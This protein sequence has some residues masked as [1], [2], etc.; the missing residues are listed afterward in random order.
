MYTDAGAI[1]AFTAAGLHYYYLDAGLGEIDAFYEGKR[2]GLSPNIRFGDPLLPPRGGNPDF[3]WPGEAGRTVF[4][5]ALFEEGATTIPEDLHIELKMEYNVGN[6]GR[7][8]LFYR[9]LNFD[10]E[11]APANAWVQ[12]TWETNGNT[13]DDF[14]LPTDPV[15][16]NPYKVYAIGIGGQNSWSQA[17]FDNVMFQSLP[18]PGSLG[19]LLLSTP[20]L[21]R[22]RRA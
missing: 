7:L 5:N 16:G 4:E 18:E 6:D 19:L 22:R 13:Y 20:L 17:A 3:Q 1:N 21:L 12:G 9:S 10:N 2:G 15:T 8:R 11:F 14:I